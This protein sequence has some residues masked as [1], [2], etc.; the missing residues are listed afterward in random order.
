MS[1]SSDFDFFPPPFKEGEVHHSS[2]ILHIA[3][4]SQQKMR[5]LEHTPIYC[6]CICRETQPSYLADT[7]PLISES[8][9]TQSTT[10]K[11]VASC[12]C[13]TPVAI[14]CFRWMKLGELESFQKINILLLH[15]EHFHM[16]F[17]NHLQSNMWAYDA[18]L[19]PPEKLRTE[20][21]ILVCFMLF[22]P[23]PSNY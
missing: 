23:T 14:S 21:Q 12:H 20:G 13:I 11:S 18:V 2:N 15:T 19:L 6:G 16:S 7:K 8:Q 1:K 17:V 4:S 9:S 22:L 3:R 10:G 5:E